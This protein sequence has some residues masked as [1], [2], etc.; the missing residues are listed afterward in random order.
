MSKVTS[1]VISK[2]VSV[3]VEPFRSTIDWS[4]ITTYNVPSSNGS[5]TT[6]PRVRTTEKTIPTELAT[7][8]PNTSPAD[9]YIREVRFNEDALLDELRDYVH[10]TYTGHYSGKYQAMDI[11]SQIGHGIGFVIGSIIKYAFR[12]G[13]K[14]GYNRKDLL[15]IA[16]YSLLALY[17]HDQ[18][19]DKDV[20]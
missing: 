17:L 6:L 8:A 7:V 4:K 3:P 16:H 2:V 15:K 11:I 20:V 18:Q 13:K 10:S 19:H 14:D 1:H 5:W 12:Y 9:K